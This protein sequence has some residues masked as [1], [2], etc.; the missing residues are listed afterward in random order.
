MKIFMGS[1]HRGFELKQELTKWLQKDYQVADV[2]PVEY[3][4]TDDYVDYTQKVIEQMD[5]E[6][7]RGILLCGSG[8]GI[9]IASNRYSEVR[10]ILG[11][12]KKVC[13]QGREHEDANVLCLPADWL[14]FDEAKECVKAFLVTPFSNEERHVRRISKINQLG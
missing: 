9:C 4:K 5:S 8:H 2:G 1:D 7:D 3:E 10:A 13:I 6:N 12:N 14:S 11:F